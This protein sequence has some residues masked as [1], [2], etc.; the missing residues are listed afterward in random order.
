[1]TAAEIAA[2]L[3]NAHREGRNWRCMCPVH[4][5]SS[6][7]LRDGR[8]GLLVKCWAGCNSVEVLTELRRRRL[9]GNAT[10][11]RHHRPAPATV[12]HDDRDGVARRIEI[13]R[14]IWDAAREA[15]GT[16][17]E[18]YLAGRGISIA[19]PPSLRFA[20]SLRRSDG[21]YRPA[22][23]A[24]IDNIDGKL[25]GVARTWLHRDAGGNW[26]RLDRAMLGRA[27]GG[28]VRLAPAGE[29]LLIGEGTETTLAG[30]EAT[31]L[32]GWATLSTSGMVALIL[33]PSVRTVIIL[34][35]NDCSGAGQ[36]A[37]RI[38]ETHWRREV[39]KVSV[40]MSLRPGEDANDCLLAA[41]GAERRNVAA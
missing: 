18:R 22:M 32:P 11:D 4:G 30:I 10:H 19:P 34:A 9:L 2:T 5:G 21:T 40:W 31:G 33:P 36:R 27:V 6:L 28:A 8:R 16:P 35:D 20:P 39:R 25:V 17:V 1:M 38:A 29:T 23:V 13:A 12:C 3:G 41:L 37:A 7:T 15:H 14:R 26:C 24:R